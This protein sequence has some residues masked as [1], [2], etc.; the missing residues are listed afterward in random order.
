[1]ADEEALVRKMSVQNAQGCRALAVKL[2]YDDGVEGERQE[3]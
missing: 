3:L 2:G 1:M